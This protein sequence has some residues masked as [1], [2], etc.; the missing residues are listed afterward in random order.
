[1]LP[2]GLARR[3]AGWRA[4]LNPLIDRDREVTTS[5]LGGYLLLWGLARLRR[6]RPR[7]LRFQVE[8]A[9]I[10]AWLGSAINAARSDLALGVEV[11]RLQ[12]LVR[13]YS[14]THARGLANFAAI[15]RALPVLAAR[16]DGAAVLAAL[17]KAALADDE[18]RALGSALVELEQPAML[19]A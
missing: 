1:M 3:A 10:E 2:A 18:S 13:G 14:D 6:F 16:A 8:E 11:I 4:W 12:R 5:G 7:S 17:H 9:R 15:M 19:A